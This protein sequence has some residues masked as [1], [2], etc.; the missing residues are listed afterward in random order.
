MASVRN[1][2]PTDDSP[3]A[4]SERHRT[5]KISEGEWLKEVRSA[6]GLLMLDLSADEQRAMARELVEPGTELQQLMWHAA[7]NSR[8]NRMPAWDVAGLIYQT[9]ISRRHPTV[10]PDQQV[11]RPEWDMY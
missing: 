2:H 3:R 11:E 9:M 8:G 10:A 4:R 7:D 1:L 6:L 5:R